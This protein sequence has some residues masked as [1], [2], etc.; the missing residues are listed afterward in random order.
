MSNLFRKVWNFRETSPLS[1]RM[2]GY[3]LVCSSLFTLFATGIQVYADYRKDVSLVDQ[4]MNLIE[5][6]YQSS[7]ARSLWS[8]DQKLL[9]VQM[10]GILNLPDIVH[11]HLQIYPDSEIEMGEIPPRIPTIK[12]KSS[13][14][15]LPTIYMSWVN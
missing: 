13:C 15:T 14:S 8:L 11:L 12:Q 10:Q 7:L 4:R 1:F 2:L 9:R 3:I 5:T 6:S